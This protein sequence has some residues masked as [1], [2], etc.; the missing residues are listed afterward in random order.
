MSMFGEVLWLIQPESVPA[1]SPG[2]GAGT[3]VFAQSLMP[4]AGI[5]SAALSRSMSASAVEVG[6]AEGSAVISTGG[7]VAA[8]GSP[9]VHPASIPPQRR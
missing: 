5:G 6:E 7:G 3:A 4:S 9:T 1:P 8:S 2:S